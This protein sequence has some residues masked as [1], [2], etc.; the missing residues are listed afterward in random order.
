MPVP[1]SSLILIAECSDFQMRYHFIMSFILK[2]QK[3][4][5]LKL[6]SQLISDTQM[7]MTPTRFYL[8]LSRI[9]GLPSTIV[10]P[11]GYH[12]D[13]L[14]YFRVHYSSNNSKDD[15]NLKF[16]MTFDA[17]IDQGD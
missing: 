17:P 12:K 7:S 4:Q 16:W 8:S 13:V 1:I 2:G 3:I 14:G 11:Y 10:K 5:K 15:K 9:F 6:I